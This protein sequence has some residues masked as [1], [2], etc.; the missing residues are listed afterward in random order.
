MNFEKLDFNLGDIDINIDNFDIDVDSSFKKKRFNKPKIIKSMFKNGV[1]YKNAVRLA[2]D[3]DLKVNEQQHIILGGSFIVGDFI[4]ALI[5]KRKR[6]VREMTISTLSMSLENI[7]S[8]KNLLEAM[9]IEKLN[10]IVSD[11]FYSHERNNLMNAIKER[12][13]IDECLNLAVSR[14]HTKIYQM[15]CDDMY[16]TVYGSANMRSSSNIEQI[17][18][19]TS[20]ECY[21]FYKDFHDDIL[22]KQNI[23][24][25]EV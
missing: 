13:D 15:K 17:T 3:I 22:S 20:K 12:L 23:V 16:I 14:I 2:D 24:N 6:F 25:R 1:H 18:I 5:K 21:D 4:E 9:V 19:D 11:Y 8:L 7:D 10:L